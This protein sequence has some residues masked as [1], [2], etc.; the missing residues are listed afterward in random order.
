LLRSRVA[1]NDDL[2]AEQ[3]ENATVGVR[4]VPACIEDGL[5]SVEASVVEAADDGAL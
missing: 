5:C 1:R 2:G 3:R 4:F